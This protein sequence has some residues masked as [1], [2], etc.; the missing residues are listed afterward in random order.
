VRLKKKFILQKIK[1]NLK[2][3]SARLLFLT[4]SGSDLYGFSSKDSDI[5]LRGVFAYKT[6]KVLGVENLE[7]VK[8]YQM[9]NYDI[10]L[11]ELRKAIRLV[12]DGNCTFVENL[13]SVPI[14]I[15]KDF[16]SLRKVLLKT[17]NKQGLILSY[18]GMAIHNY[19]KYLSSI[20][21]TAPVKKFLYVFRG[22]LCARNILENS[23][24]EPNINRLLERYNYPEIKL[25]VELKQK[26][27]ENGEL[28]NTNTIRRLEELY[29]ELLEMINT[30]SKKISFNPISKELREEINKELIAFRTK[31]LMK[32]RKGYKSLTRN[33]EV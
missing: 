13:H 15:S 31:E 33:K 27:K 32:K 28:R 16:K 29:Q 20:S 9:G 30:K 5:D 4:V 14:Y 6:T 19:K 23:E 25:L 1:E 10:V 12:L 17:L 22:L 26:G 21:K 3:D 2:K 18:R 24:I 8:K 11:Y 7:E